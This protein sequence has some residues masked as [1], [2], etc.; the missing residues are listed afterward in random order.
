MSGV[1][2]VLGV[3]LWFGLGQETP[4]PVVPVVT[5]TVTPSPTPTVTP[6]PTPDAHGDPHA[7]RAAD[8]AESIDDA[9][10]LARLSA[11]AHR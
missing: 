5:P 3:G 9:T 4:E 7:D 10:V 8:P 11:P 1:V 6:T 2:G